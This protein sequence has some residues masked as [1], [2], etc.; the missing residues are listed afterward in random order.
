MS[1]K[2]WTEATTQP[3]RNYRWLLRF[4]GENGKIIWWAKTVTVPSFEV[5]ET[6]HD[7]LDNKYYYPGRVTWSEISMT[8]VDP[9]SPDATS[10]TLEILKKSGYMVKGINDLNIPT[11]RPTLSKQKAVGS[12]GRIRMQLLDA[13]GLILENWTVENAFIKSAKYGDLDYSSDDLRTIELSV[14]YDWASCE[15]SNRAEAEA[16]NFDSRAGP[17]AITAD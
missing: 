17:P 14:R 13:D 9:V 10:D 12:L 15:F 5:S 8:L 3:K 7:F 16:V 1:N 2:F 11:T 4:G 6:E